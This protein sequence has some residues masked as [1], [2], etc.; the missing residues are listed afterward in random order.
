MVALAAVGS[1]LVA[2]V[3]SYTI[4]L[5]TTSET[6]QL[7]N[8]INQVAAKGNELLTTTAA[9]NYSIRVYLQL[10]ATIGYQQYWIRATND[11][12]STWIEASLGQMTVNRAPNQVFLPKG[13][14]ASG[15]FVG[16]YGSAILE[17]YV[18]GSTLQLNLASSGG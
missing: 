7:N 9:T 11:S 13:T 12:S 4:T 6:Q 16:G 2:T 5:R 15:Y 18:N 3:N 17:S 8:L 1:L 10:P 14:S